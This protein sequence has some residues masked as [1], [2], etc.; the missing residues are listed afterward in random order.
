MVSAG[1]A[2]AGFAVVADEVRNLALRAA[3][4]ARDTAGLIE[5]TVSKVKDG[6]NLVG[7]TNSSFAEV[8]TGSAI[9]VRGELHGADLQIDQVIHSVQVDIQGLLPEGGESDP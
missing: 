1:E 6:K 9:A 4:A 2:G 7:A 3:N 8:S 5:A